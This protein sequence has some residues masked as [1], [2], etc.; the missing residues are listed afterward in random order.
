M[1]GTAL[2]TEV[3]TWRWT[4]LALEEVICCQELF[5]G[6]RLKTRLERVKLEIGRLEKYSRLLYNPFLQLQGSGWDI[7]GQEN[8]KCFV[9]SPWNESEDKAQ[10]ERGGI[11]PSPHVGFS[12]LALH[13]C[14]QLSGKLHVLF[15]STLLSFIL[16]ILETFFFWASTKV[17]ALY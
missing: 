3:G 9:S 13:L 15:L 14:I 5:S 4:K 2:D 16:F 1:K 6:V 17:E 11:N 12:F 8:Y 10:L 7:S